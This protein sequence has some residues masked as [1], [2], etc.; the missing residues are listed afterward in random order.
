[1][2]KLHLGGLGVDETMSSLGSADWDDF[3][4]CVGWIGRWV[5]ST[6]VGRRSSGGLVS[7]KKKSKG[8]RHILVSVSRYGSN[9]RRHGRMMRAVMPRLVSIT[10][11]S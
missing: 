10:A 1:M 3:F 6:T 11:S 8:E 4:R 5:S 9:E 7:K 2:G